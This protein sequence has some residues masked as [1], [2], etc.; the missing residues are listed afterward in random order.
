MLK[1]K[2]YIEQSETSNIDF[3][4]TICMINN[5]KYYMNPEIEDQP[6]SSS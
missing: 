4:I 1:L 6:S 5:K 3:E 2:T